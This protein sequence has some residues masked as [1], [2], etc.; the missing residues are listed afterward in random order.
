MNQ[1]LSVSQM[2]ILAWV[3][4]LTA[5]GLE[6]FVVLWVLPQGS[7]RIWLLNLLIPTGMLAAAGSLLWR[8]AEAS[9]V[10]ATTGPGWADFG[11]HGWRSRLRRQ[12]GPVMTVLAFL[13]LS[14][15][16]L[17]DRKLSGKQRLLAGGLGLA[18]LTLSVAVSFPLDPGST[19]DQ[20]A[21]EKSLVRELTGKNKVYWV[22]GESLFHLCPEALEA[23]GVA[24]TADNASAD[25][26]DA[27]A[28]GGEAAEDQPRQDQLSEIQSGSVKAA[29]KAGMRRLTSTWQAEAL[30][31]CGYTT[32]QVD[33]V[34]AAGD[35]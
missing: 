7:H 12:I 18:I 16:V 19:R 2:R 13:P 3:A 4:W 14:V 5:I 35:F 1:R 27:L 26:S 25:A 10:L 8:R 28:P 9:R 30:N 32:E 34:L 20:R 24:S 23:R 29:H 15:L 31:H 6:L 11:G 33:A 22:E 21:A 17:F